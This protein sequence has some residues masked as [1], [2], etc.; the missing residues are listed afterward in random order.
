M[1]TLHVV[2]FS[3]AGTTRTVAELTAAGFGGDTVVYDLFQH[4]QREP[5]A[6]AAE[7]TLLL[8]MPVYAGVIPHLCVEQVRQFRGAGTPALAA[9]VYGNRDYD[10]ALLELSD[11]LTEGGFQLIGAGAFIA[12]HCIFPK[13]GAGR[14]DELDRAAIRSFARACRDLRDRPGAWQGRRLTVKG[15]PGYQSKAEKAPHMPFHPTGGRECDGCGACAAVCPTGSID[16]ADPKGVRGESCLCCG[17]CIAH[18]PKHCRGYHHV[19]YG[20]AA[21]A[22]SAKFS[23][24][25]DPEIFLLG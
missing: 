11:L 10:D 13:A 9:A 3:A 15:S 8:A 19:A 20:P 4:P 23:T 18:C 17:A 24:R 12:Q 14:P 21:L 5:V 16:A 22:F 2:Y 1:S 6:I 7:D 25:R